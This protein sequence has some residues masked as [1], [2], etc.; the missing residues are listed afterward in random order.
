MQGGQA[1][2][3]RRSCSFVRRSTRG[4]GHG[5]GQGG[6]SGGDARR[7]YHRVS[8]GDGDQSDRG[9]LATDNRHGGECHLRNSVGA[10]AVSE[11]SARYDRCGCRCSGAT[12]REGANGTRG[13]GSGQS[14]GDG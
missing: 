8:V 12:D 5:M 1:R 6:D 10:R 2:Q 4:H 13:K 9:R 14:Q 3:D 7:R 11:G